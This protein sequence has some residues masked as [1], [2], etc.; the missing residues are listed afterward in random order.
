MTKAFSPLTC[1]QEP[2][3]KRIVQELLE[4]EKAYVAR[5]HL[6]DQVRGQNTALSCS[7]PQHPGLLSPPSLSLMCTSLVLRV[8]TWH[9]IRGS[10]SLSPP[11]PGVGAE[12]RI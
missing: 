12:M 7:K 9:V 4:T 11:L 10:F 2:E 5:L 3:E 6:L 8:R 1:L